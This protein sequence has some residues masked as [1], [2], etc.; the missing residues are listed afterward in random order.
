MNLKKAKAYGFLAWHILRHYLHKLFPRPRPDLKRFFEHYGAE[1]IFAIDAPTR[2][3]MPAFS[4]CYVCRLCDTVC[5]NLADHPGFLPPSYVV[6][7]FSRSLTD[8]ARFRPADTDCG[9]ACRDCED[10]CPQHVPIGD[11][12]A[13][14]RRHSAHGA[15]T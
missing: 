3:K 14:M 1:G 4:R 6:G 10:I 13:H 9:D 12:I 2:A 7:G 11:M 15:S 8:Y 5:P